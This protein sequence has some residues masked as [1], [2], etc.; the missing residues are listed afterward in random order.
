MIISRVRE[1]EGMTKREKGE[2]KT[3]S[4]T[5]P[6]IHHAKVAA[7]SKQPCLSK[8]ERT[9]GGTRGL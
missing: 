4:G 3:Q 1:N 6:T 9:A 7:F 5:R 8:N 2:E